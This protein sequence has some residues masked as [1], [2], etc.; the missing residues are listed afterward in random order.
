V[1]AQPKELPDGLER[2]LRALDAEATRRAGRVDAEVVAAR[3]LARLRA[4]AEPAGLP[5]VLPGRWAVPSLPGWARVTAAAAMV[6][7]VAGSVLLKVIGPGAQAVPV[8]VVAVSLDSLNATQLESLLRVT[9]EVRP[10]AA[11]AGLVSG[12][13]EDLTE[14]QLRAVLQAVQQVQGEAL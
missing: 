14:T 13:W 12:S 8:P 1:N 5:R 2:A 4:D 9:A 11:A 6:V 3:V 7:V 10:V